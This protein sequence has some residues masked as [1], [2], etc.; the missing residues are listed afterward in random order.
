MS[1]A[2]KQQMI[3]RFSERELVELTDRVQPYTEA[4]VDSVLDRALETA[5]AEVDSYLRGRYVVPVIPAPSLL[6]D[7]ACDV[8]RWKLCDSIIPDAVQKFRDEAISRLRD[9]ARGV[10]QLEASTSSETSSAMPQ[11]NASARIFTRDSMRG[12]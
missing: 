7:I 11:F 10:I 4:I 8:A 9:I 3:D 2:T 1:Y 5:D 12:F 6:I